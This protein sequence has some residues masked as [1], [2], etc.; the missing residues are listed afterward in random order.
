MSKILYIIGNGFDKHHKLK[1]D[2]RDYFQFLVKNHPDIL[3]DMNVS[4]F[5][6]GLDTVDIDGSLPED[7]DKLWSNLEMMLEYAYEEYFEETVDCYAPD[8]TDEHPN[9][10]GVIFQV[11]DDKAPFSKFTGDYLIEWIK[12]A[13]SD[14]CIKDNSL[15]LSSKK[16]Y[17]SFNYTNTL[18]SIYNIPDAKILHIH[19]SLKENLANGTPLQFGN[20]KESA[21]KLQRWL[22]NKYV[23]NPWGCWVTDAIPSIVELCKA[24]TKNLK[25]NYECL[26]K[27]IENKKFDE[28]V[29]MGH[30]F[31]G[32]DKPYYDDI[33]VPCLEKCKWIFYVHND[34]DKKNVLKFKQEH[35]LIRVEEIVW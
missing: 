30:S 22:E 8:Y 5:F 35:P 26:K 12:S 9:F 16:Y 15:N 25:Q 4:K 31:M 3:Y 21:E 27:F 2:Y 6:N 29:V 32:V 34:D 10:G 17:L 18:Q 14:K 7:Y 11:E 28:V 1:T 24:L 13:E 33:I 19:G 20:P 23:D